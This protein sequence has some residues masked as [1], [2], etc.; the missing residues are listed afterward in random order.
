MPTATPNDAPA[1]TSPL[2][3]ITAA[4]FATKMRAS[5]STLSRLERS[6]PSFPK[7]GQLA[8]RGSRL[9]LESAVD[10]YLVEKLS[11]PARPNTERV[12]KAIA[13]RAANRAS[14]RGKKTSHVARAAAQGDRSSGKSRATS[15]AI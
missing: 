6:D 5:I 11:Q 2:R 14:T 9:W 12:A 7:P 1:G 3:L 10:A 8:S 4:E 13:Q 15:A